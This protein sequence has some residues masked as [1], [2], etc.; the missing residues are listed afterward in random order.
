MQPEILRME[1]IDKSF[2]GVKV[3]EGVTFELKKGEVHS[4]LGENGA[5]KSTLMKILTGVYTKDQ[6][7]ILLRGKEVEISSPLQAQQMGISMIHQELN[8]I[9]NLTVAENIFIGREKNFGR[10]GWV[11]TK[12]MNQAA[13]AV[14]E[15]LGLDYDP[16]QIVGQL[17]VGEQ[18]MVEIAKALSFDAEILVMDE[19]TAAL[20]DREI[21]RLFQ[22]VNDLREQGVGIVYISHRME[23]LFQICDRV[24]VMRDGH[25]IGTR[26]MNETTMD[27]LVKMMVGRELTDRF[28]K[29]SSVQDEVILEVKHLSSGDD[30]QDISFSLRKGE[31][32]G[33]AG[34]MGAGR[35]EV[36]RG[37]F[38][39]DKRD[40]GDIYVSGEK[41]KIQS[42]DQAIQNGIAL[43]TED[44][45]DQ[46]LVLGLSVRE[47][48]ALANLK[49]ISRNGLIKHSEEK[50]IVEEQIDRLKIKTPDGNQLVKSLSG[51][52]QQKVVLAKWLETH[53][54]VLILDEPTRG[55]D[56]GAK[57]E[58]YQLM[59]ELTKQGIGI[60]MISSELP[61]LLGMSDR[62]LVMREGRITG[63]FTRE[64]AKQE[65]IMAC[66]TGG[67]KAN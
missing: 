43:V 15:R 63:E 53:P 31:V 12:R 56:V 7:R 3:L 22:L 11:N 62:I 38:G 17:S 50:A 42:P 19:P 61:E 34:L 30:Y 21:E 16:T 23:E 9:P 49:K 65:D 24:T 54:K 20:T 14:L 29:Q 46:G 66:A 36:V 2:P 55:I 52:N 27:E 40:Q 4:L 26:E 32:L 6:G 41:I 51:G 5:G 10:Y 18:Q 60:L 13:K 37:I 1:G 8:L 57:V 39:A 48:I 25:Y 33:I 59:N 45:K 47:N 28:P 67:R 44:R 64:E 58:I 35:T